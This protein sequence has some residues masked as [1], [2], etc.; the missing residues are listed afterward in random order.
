MQPVKEHGYKSKEQHRE[1][2]T[3]EPEKEVV[4]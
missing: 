1:C 3:E 4:D 2:D